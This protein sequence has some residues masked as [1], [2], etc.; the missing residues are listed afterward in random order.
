MTGSFHFMTAPHSQKI[1]PAER[2]RLVTSPRFGTV[3]TDHMVTIEWSDDRG[4]HN[5]WV[6]PREPFTLDPASAVLHYAQEIFEGMKA[7]P[8]SAGSIALF[9]PRDNARRFNQSAV[10]MAMPTLPEDIFIEAV[11]RLVLAD[12]EWLPPNCGSLYLR[13]FMFATD[14]FLGV[15]P[16]KRYIFCVIASPVGAYFEDAENPI[17]VWVTDRYSRAAEGGTG[18]AKC[19]GN[20]A[21]SL[22]A[23]SEATLNGCDQAIF[24]DAI[25][26]R[27][28]EELG[29]MNIFFVMRDGGII[30]PPLGTIL[31][32]ITRDS[33]TQLLRADGRYVMETRYS[34]EQWREDALNGRLSEV[35][36]CGTAAGI[37]NV[38]KVCFATGNFVIGDGKGGAVAEDLRNRLFSIQRGEGPDDFGWRMDLGERTAA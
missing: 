16:A 25:E 23:Q 33:V 6:R 20:Y 2:S 36:V 1:P 3:F 11:E 34:F 37:A 19:G 8:T 14:V 12:A 29:G 22:I 9:R 17:T 26:H 13:P 24:L 27:W 31:P 32:G 28:V 18:G 7:H 30:T 5:A 4:W 21:A 35:F 15:R 10:R 38:G